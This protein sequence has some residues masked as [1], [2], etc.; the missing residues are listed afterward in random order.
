MQPMPLVP[1]AVNGRRHPSVSDW[2]VIGRTPLAQIERHALPVG[3]PPM[4]E[5]TA[6]PPQQGGN[7]DL[8]RLLPFAGNQGSSQPAPRR[9][10]SP[11]FL[12][13]GGERQGNQPAAI[14]PAGPQPGPSPSPFGQR[15]ACPAGPQP[16]TEEF[17]F[18]KRLAESKAQDLITRLNQAWPTAGNVTLHRW[19][20]AKN[21]GFMGDQPNRTVTR[22]QGAHGNVGVADRVR[23]AD[24]PAG[25]MAFLFTGNAFT[26]P[27][28]RDDRTPASLGAAYGPGVH[29]GLPPVQ[30]MIIMP[31]MDFAGQIGQAVS[32]LQELACPSSGCLINEQNYETHPAVMAFVR[33]LDRLIGIFSTN[34]QAAV[35][36]GREFEA[37]KANLLANL[38]R[39]VIASRSACQGTG[40][41]TPSAS[42]C[43]ADSSER[44]MTDAQAKMFADYGVVLR[45]AKDLGG[46]RGCYVRA[47]GAAIPKPPAAGKQCLAR[48]SGIPG[49]APSRDAEGRP[50][51]ITDP[52]VVTCQQRGG[53]LQA[54][55]LGSG[56]RRG[57]D[58]PV[59]CLEP[60]GGMSQGGQFQPGLQQSTFQQGQGW[61][62]GGSGGM[63]VR[64]RPVS[65]FG[66]TGVGLQQPMQQF[67][68]P[69]MQ[70]QLPGGQ[71]PG[72][73]F[74]DPMAAFAAAATAPTVSGLS[75]G[76]SGLAVTMPS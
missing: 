76:N 12:P 39:N 34:P 5:R 68:Q 56:A 35:Q 6:A 64:L 19:E 10:V 70:P 16:G 26:D 57:E 37:M 67:Q 74:G 43:D 46:G 4:D 41:Q 27:V 52:T 55:I 73:V 18:A 75:Y 29:V 61:Q 31:Q 9:N 53:R 71:Y 38:A 22:G 14:S 28:G 66:R 65:N 7:N 44:E 42:G 2:P 51:C 21:H 72:A 25:T 60:G 62:Q 13:Y 23:R 59:A 32:Q 54:Q 36:V 8:R 48:W 45:K 30:S 58:M 33:Y 63:Q 1:R 69:G 40:N 11:E 49:N 50:F 47:A 20:D 15:S 3:G 24:V 17:R